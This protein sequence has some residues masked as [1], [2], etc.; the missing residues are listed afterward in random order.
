MIAGDVFGEVA[1]VAEELVVAV[2]CVGNAAEA[3]EALEA[4]DFSGDVDGAG[5]VELGLGGAVGL[6]AGYF[7]PKSGFEGIEGDAGFGGDVTG[8]DGA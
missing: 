2:E 6:E 5:A 4:G 1:R 7:F 3:A 8:G